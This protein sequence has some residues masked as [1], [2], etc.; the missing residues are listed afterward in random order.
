VTTSPRLASQATK[1]GD[2]GGHAGDD[3]LVVLGRAEDD[4]PRA[5]TIRRPGGD[6][7]YAV[8]GVDVHDKFDVL[9]F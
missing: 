2:P 4:Q 5:G 8:P 1:P 9:I 3:R 7:R 6:E